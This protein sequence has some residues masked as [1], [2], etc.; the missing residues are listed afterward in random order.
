MLA[1][2]PEADRALLRPLLATLAAL[3]AL[4]ARA[5][6]A[7][8]WY[9]N[10][11][12]VIAASVLGVAGDY[13]LD[14]AEPATL[15]DET[16]AQGAGFTGALLKGQVRLAGVQIDEAPVK[17]E[18]LDARTVFLPTPVAGVIGAD[19]L[20]NKVL[21]VQFAPCRVQLWTRRPP[22]FGPG[23]ALPLA[24]RGPRPVVAAAV[25]DGHSAWP[26]EFTPGTGVDR[27]LRLDDRL[28][29]APAAKKPLELY[30]GGI[31]SGRL[32][33]L[34]FGGLAFQDIDT[35]LFK[36]EFATPAPAGLIGAPVLAHFRLR[37]DFPGRR[38]WLAPASTPE[39]KRAPEKTPGP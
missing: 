28:A 25:S 7:P 18:K 30:P 29:Q 14:T 32:A 4:P 8:C 27:P 15:L 39:T 23:L 26:G 2:H 17:V 33:G 6:V 5:E 12:V 24:W 20:R 21:E 31:G 1:A 16:R 19:V 22:A 37:F 35:A 10:G 34:S 13:I 9:D 3:A 36:G 11:V 38:L